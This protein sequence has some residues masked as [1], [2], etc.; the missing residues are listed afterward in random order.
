MAKGLL[1]KDI[2][3][4]EISRKKSSRKADKRNQ[5]A[6][7]GGTWSRKQ[8]VNTGLKKKTYTEQTLSHSEPGTYINN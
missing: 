5:K 7:A 1:K 8:E 4:R 3:E 2:Q 6:L